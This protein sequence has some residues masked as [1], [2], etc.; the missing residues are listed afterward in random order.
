SVTGFHAVR[1]E[2]HNH[3]NGNADEHIGAIGNPEDRHR[4][5]QVTQR[6][7]AN[8]GNGGEEQEA[9]D[10]ELLARGGKRP[11]C[12]ED[13]DAGI[14]EKGD[15]VHRGPAAAVTLRTAEALRRA[16]SSALPWRGPF[17]PVWAS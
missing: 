2:E 11:G 14:V 15:K 13:G 3:S 17:Q 5:D 1:A 16:A 12:G 10:V 9:Y 6:A 7:A 4:Q 8:A